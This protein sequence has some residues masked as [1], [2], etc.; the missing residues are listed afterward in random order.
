MNQQKI[1]EYIAKKRKEHNMSQ[2][3]LAE[4]LGVSNKTVSKWE[5]GKCM[6]DYS[7]IKQLCQTLDTSVGE[8]LNGD[9]AV[10]KAVMED[11]T[12]S[13]L[14]RISV[15][16]KERIYFMGIGL[17]FMGIL[18]LVLSK[19]MGGTNVQDFISGLLFGISLG[20]ILVGIFVIIRNLVQRNAG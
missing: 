6:P 5:N 20:E 12:F 10:N 16:E 3:Q 17:V 8:L 15:L 13:I 9:D 19:F 1:G 18:L 4:K 7:V 11:Q 2:I 14:E